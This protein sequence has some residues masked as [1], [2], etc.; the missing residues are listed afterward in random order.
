MPD[1]TSIR[2]RLTLNRDDKSE[3]LSVVVVL[4]ETNPTAAKVQLMTYASFQE[5]CRFDMAYFPFDQQSCNMCISGTQYP[6]DEVTYVTDVYVQEIFVQ[7]GEWHLLGIHG[8]SA[9][10]G[11]T[12]TACL[13]INVQRRFIYYIIN[14]FIPTITICVLNTIGLFAAIDA[15]QDELDFAALGQTTLLSLGVMLLTVADQTPKGTPQ[16]SL[17]G[18]SGQLIRSSIYQESPF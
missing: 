4:N 15:E 7:G 9:N 13:T 8:F 2:F 16:V 6:K 17:L 10:M 14:L 12:A 18:K 5:R 3:E 1:L 11:E